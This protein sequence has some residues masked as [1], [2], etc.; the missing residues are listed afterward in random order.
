MMDMVLRDIKKFGYSEVVLW[1]FKD[2]L[3]AR[4]FYE[5]N[6]FV[7]NDVTKPAFDTE[8]VLYSKFL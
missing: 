3:R 2:N 7:L 6:G 5:R 4:A 1:V 8:E